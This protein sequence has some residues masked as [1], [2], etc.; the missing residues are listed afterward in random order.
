MHIIVRDERSVGRIIKENTDSEGRMGWNYHLSILRESNDL[1]RELMTTPR[2]AETFAKRINLL[3]THSSGRVYNASIYERDGFRQSLGIRKLK[4]LLNRVL[5]MYSSGKL[6]GDLLF[7]KTAH[8]GCAFLNEGWPIKLAQSNNKFEHWILTGNLQWV[9]ALRDEYKY[10]PAPQCSSSASDDIDEYL[11]WLVEVGSTDKKQAHQVCSYGN[12]NMG[13]YMNRIQRY[14]RRVELVN[15]LKDTA[16]APE[17]WDYYIEEHGIPRFG[18]WCYKNG[19]VF[20][21][22]G[23]PV[24]D[25]H[26]IDIHGN[27]N[28]ELGGIT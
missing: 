24:G 14:V 21:Y 8:G 12:E 3:S 17:E 9:Y 4:E 2:G 23:G 7:H 1:W 6:K 13:R 16:H 20:Y 28:T 11:R 19:K 27:R 22:I 18:V 26:S 15:V 5:K 25:V 10:E